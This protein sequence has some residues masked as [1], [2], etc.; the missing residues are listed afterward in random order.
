MLLVA[1]Q[2]YQWARLIEVLTCINRDYENDE[3]SNKSL[4]EMK[5]VVARLSADIF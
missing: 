1:L 4:Q 5:F 3:N 2:T